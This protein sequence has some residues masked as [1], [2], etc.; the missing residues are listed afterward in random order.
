L[1]S[2]C[3]TESA[4]AELLARILA[5][6]P[7][8]DALLRRALVEDEGRSLFSVV[9]ERLG[10]LFEPRLCDE[11]ARLFAR[12]VEL[13][14]P[15]IK[16]VD[17]LARYDRVREV[18]RCKK[19]L[20]RNIFVLSR[21]TLGADVAVTSVML[22]ALR[23]R[24][25]E[26]HI[27]FVGPQ[28]NFELFQTDKQISHIPFAYP[29]GGSLVERLKQWGRFAAADSIVVDP[30]S[31][32]TQ[33]GILPVCEEED[34]FFFESRSYGSTTN[35]PLP[36]LASRWTSDVFSVPGRAWIAPKHAPMTCDAAVSFGVGGNEQ[37]RIGDAFEERLLRHVASR[38]LR[39]LL[40]AG[41][42]GPETSRARELAARVPGVELY[43]GAFAPFA[44]MISQAAMYI[45]Y[46]SAG[47]HVAG[48]TGVPLVS[49]FAGYPSERM[50][51]R[52]MPHGQAARHIVKVQPGGT[53]DVLERAVAAVD[54]LL[55]AR[56]R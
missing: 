24:F 21:I 43:E 56:P 35:Q 25:P 17:L 37:K 13:L 46:D 28:R 2:T 6:D 9:V 40:D 33:L 15:E 12:V 5:G 8:P 53:A 26:S 38:R 50:F 51:Q 44:S 32:L 48:A 49:I 39:V 4:S 41:A 52:W 11:Y 45:G 29:R 10:D 16:A 47:G 31:R 22:D 14:R 42:G 27:H 55:A 1:A 23:R 18:R 30:D 20:I 19:R 54:A 7:W 34:Y 3:P 36:V